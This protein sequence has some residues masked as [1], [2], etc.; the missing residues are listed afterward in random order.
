MCGGYARPAEM[1][2]LGVTA[3]ASAWRELDTYDVL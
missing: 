3:R 1:T 2:K